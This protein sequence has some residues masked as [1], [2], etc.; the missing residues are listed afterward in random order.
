MASSTAGSATEHEDDESEY[1]DV[2]LL[3]RT[4]LGKSTTANKL[5]QTES[6]ND[7]FHPYWE[8]EAQ[9]SEATG[10]VDDTT[11]LFKVAEGVD[12]VTHS[13]KLVSNE[14]TKV[15]V[16]DTP[17]FADT[18]KTKQ[19]GVFGGNLQTFRSILKAQEINDL[20]F[21][22]VL[23]FF[24]L[25]GPPERAEGTLQEEIKIMHG[26][27]GDEIF[28]IMVIVATN[29]KR[30]M[31]KQEDFDEEDIDITK[32]V[33]MAA[34]KKVLGEKTT[35]ES[36]PPVVYLPYFEPSVIEKVVGAPVLY[37]EP[38]KSPVVVEVRKCSI[39]ELIRKEKQKHKGR[40]LQFKD[41][42]AKC[43]CKLIYEHTPRG[44]IITW[45]I[46][47][48]GESEQ[49]ILYSD[50]KCHPILYPRHTTITKII[51]GIAHVATLG[52]FVGIGKLRGKK[53][54]P[55]FTN[56]EEM[57]ANCDEPAGASGCCKVDQ[58]VTLKLKDG[59]EKD[60]T[61]E[62]KT[63]LDKYVLKSNLHIDKGVTETT[64][65]YS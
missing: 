36:C 5:L 39:E 10:G 16:L 51:G 56:D 23:Y 34:M 9:S 28:Q 44:K 11:V 52:I 26:F 46:V 25:R 50:S 1:Y 22:R 64:V 29:R 20:A 58:K 17:G 54:W 27:L 15:R 19:F 49:S 45:I 63:K 3:G 40:K 43:S 57:C 6:S 35:I 18:Q 42:C 12:S 48:D 38:L 8:E 31:R 37:D 33:F 21:C 41:R 4:G 60:I 61:T 32:T 53:V 7:I 62:H 47:E 14:F 59:T 65:V 55:G 30:K 24:P 2:L 13:C